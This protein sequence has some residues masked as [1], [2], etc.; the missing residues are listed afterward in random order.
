MTLN[1]GRPLQFSRPTGNSN[2]DALRAVQHE[3]DEILG[4]GSYLN[5]GGTDLRPQDL[6][7]WSAAGV[8]NRTTSGSRYFSINGGR[9]AIVGL[10]QQS[11]YDYGDW[12]S[13]PCPQASPLVQNALSCPGQYSDISATSPEGINLDV[14]GYDLVTPATGPS[15]AQLQNIS[16]R[17][18]VLNNDNALI[19]GFIVTGSAPKKVLL[20]AIGP[21]LGVAGALRNPT[22]ELHFPNVRIVSNDN[23]K[24]NDQTGQSQEAAIRAT[25]IP[26]PNDFESATLQTL[27]PGAYTAIVRGNSG[28]TL[29]LIDA[30]D[31]DQAAPSKLANISTRGFV[32]TGNNVMIGG[33]IVGPATPPG[34]T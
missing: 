27:A 13:A 12:F 26:P 22:L 32:Q 4:L 5:I 7:T 29:G 15:P 17:L 2:F 25:T 34:R 9:N 19:G 30:Y 1:A 8:R 16:T 10:N 11:G 3:M 28:G 20:R 6:F 23:W 14:I 21:S 24:I 31:L 33:F 18:N